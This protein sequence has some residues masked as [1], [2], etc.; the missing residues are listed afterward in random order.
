M[1]GICPSC[2]DYRELEMVAATEGINVRGEQI[3]VD[4]AHLK[5]LS[6]GEEFVDP[7]SKADPIDVAFREYRRRHGMLQPEEIREL[8]KRYGLTQSEMGKILGWGF[9]TLSRYENGALQ[10]DAHEKILHLIER[11][12]NLLKLIQETPEALSTDK[13]SILQQQLFNDIH[14]KSWARAL[15]EWIETNDIDIYSGYKKFDSSKLCNAILYFC[16][17]NGVF[18]T[19]LNK[20]LFYADFKHFKEYSV[21]ITGSRY[22]PIR[23]GPVPDKWKY[24]LAIL[25]D[26]NDLEAEEVICSDNVSGEKCIAKKEPDLNIFSETELK[27]LAST[28]EYFGTFTATK[29]STYSHLEKAY[30]DTPFRHFISYLFAKDIQ[31]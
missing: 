13:K 28:K 14:Q 22:V 6:C 8:R 19:V 29:I 2:E 24:F 16:K 7:S 5:C 26:E 15:E 25:T 21:S 17:G 30:T 18:T 1:K 12:E 11:P 9:A 3:K 20:L 4:T 23:Y 27:I 31:F 10:D